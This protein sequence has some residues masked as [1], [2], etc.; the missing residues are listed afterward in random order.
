MSEL[1]DLRRIAYGRTGSVAEEAAAADARAAL[2]RHEAASRAAR[3][4]D[5]FVRAR[6]SAATAAAAEPE[7]EQPPAPAEAAAPDEP[8]YLRR[9]SAT[10]RL[11][12]LPVVVAFV[13]GVAVT[14]AS[15]MVILQASRTG[16]APETNTSQRF[17]D[18]S[19]LITP[20]VA[21]EGTLAIESGDLEAA[22]LV[23]NR[24]R[25]ASD[26]I[27]ELDDSIVPDSTRL[28]KALDA[29][30]AYAA[31]S[32]DGEICLI[33]I[34]GPINT[35]M[36]CALPSGF[37]GQGL[38]IAWGKSAQSVRVHWDGVDVVETVTGQ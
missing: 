25:E 8:G 10:W 3:E 27:L 6:A 1:D 24:P 35:D 29:S 33:V 17:L 4:A 26:F 37:A 11:W 30:A 21:E 9:L 19:Q 5:E 13:V 20:G 28:L 31:M 22:S 36:A 2:A 14:V 32:Q 15:G 18:D 34:S 16:P 7:P 12:A 38:S 23:L